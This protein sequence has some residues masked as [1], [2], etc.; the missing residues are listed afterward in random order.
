MAPAA[1][2][3]KNFRIQGSTNDNIYKMTSIILNL[4]VIPVPIKLIKTFNL[5]LNLFYKTFNPSK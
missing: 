1:G 4:I 2:T 5:L 3:P